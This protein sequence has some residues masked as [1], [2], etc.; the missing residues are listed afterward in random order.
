MSLSPAKRRIADIRTH[1]TALPAGFSVDTIK[2]CS[3]ES[4]F[5]PAPGVIDVAEKALRRMQFYAEQ[6]TDTLQQAIAQR[7]RIDP[8][9]IVCGPGSDELLARLC[10]A[11]LGTDDELLYSINGYAKFA[12][13]ALANDAVPVRVPDADFQVSVDNLLAR[14]TSQTRMVMVANPDNPTGTWLSGSE[15][16]RLHEGL[17]A[18][19]LLVVDS[20][21]AEY[22]DDPCYTMPSALVDDHDNVVMTRT[23]SKIHGLA[24]LRLGWLYGPSSIVETL[25]RIGTTF[26]ISNVALDCG[27]AAMAN[28]AYQ[29]EIKQRNRVLRAKLRDD[30]CALGLDPVE[31]QTNFLLIGFPAT[32]PDAAGA[33]EALWS[34]NVMVRRFP[35]PAFANHIRVSIGTEAEMARFHSIMSAYVDE[36][37]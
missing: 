22:V 19:V 27:V 35:T 11:Y 1:M 15:I 8:D 20:A 31:S 12:N 5:G 32:G 16:A 30:M 23:F 2:L 7:E 34:R 37:C 36:S 26:P 33:D 17:P 6:G 3:N 10:R 21:Y 24:G 28:E 29:T 9:R 25:R 14:V 13:Y 4:A 18:S